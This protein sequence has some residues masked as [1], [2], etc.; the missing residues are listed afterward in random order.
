MSDSADP[1]LP[2]P[3]PTKS[4]LRYKKAN[5]TWLSDFMA[6]VGEI[7]R[8]KILAS[9]HG[10][11]RLSI[12]GLARHAEGNPDVI[13]RHVKRLR[14]SGVLEWVAIQDEDLRVCHH[15]LK[16]GIAETDADGK[17]WLNLGKV[18]I[19]LD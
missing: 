10:D 17:R 7:N 16:P 11:R 18:K 4:G 3:E 6:L 14:E 9:L 5:M 19:C 15:R 8:L 1:S 2:Q 13:S 12:Q